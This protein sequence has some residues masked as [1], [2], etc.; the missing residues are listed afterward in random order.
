MNIYQKVYEFASSAGA[1]EGYVYR[2]R[3]DDIDMDALKNWAGNLAGAYEQLPPDVRREFQTSCDQTLG[4][5]IRSV[6]SFL[7]ANHDIVVKLKSMVKGALPDSPD[8]FQKTKW[9]AKSF[10]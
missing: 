1:F 10:T 6:V 4:R 9:F 3:I 5:A 2:K 8:D 7:E